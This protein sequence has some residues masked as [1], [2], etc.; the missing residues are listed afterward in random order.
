M[1]EEEEFEKRSTLYNWLF[2]AL[3]L[4]NKQGFFKGN[5]PQTVKELSYYLVHPDILKAEYEKKIQSET[6]SLP[7]GTE[8]GLPT[9]GTT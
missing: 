3:D 8:T 9:D 6:E 5:V 1:T 4:L 2:P 7:G